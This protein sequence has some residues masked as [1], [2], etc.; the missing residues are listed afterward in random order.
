MVRLEAAHPFGDHCNVFT[1]MQ[2]F[3][4]GWESQNG[5][6]RGDVGI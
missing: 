5:E 2:G 4:L 3:A 6:E 1:R